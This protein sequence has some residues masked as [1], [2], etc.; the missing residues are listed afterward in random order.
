MK[1]LWTIPKDS[2][3]GAIK[4]VDNVPARN[5]I[6]CSEYIRI[7]KAGKDGAHFSL[8]SD[9]SAR[10][11]VR[12]GAKFPFASDVFLDRR[13]FVP[14]VAGGKESKTTTYEFLIRDGGKLLVKHGNRRAVYE[15]LQ[16]VSGYESLPAIESPHETELDKSW[17]GMVDVASDCA[18]DDPIS[19]NLN[20]VYLYPDKKQL[21]V[22]ASNG[23]VVFLGTVEKQK[24]IREPIAF[25]LKLIDSLKLDNASKLVWTNKL[26]V[27]EF[28]KGKIW[29]AVKIKARKHFPVH[30]LRKMVAD[31]QNN[32]TILAVNS[33][34]LSGIAE[35]LH[36]Y[37]HALSRD[38]MHLNVKLTKDSKRVVVFSGS[39]SSRFEEDLQMLH[40]AKDDA[41]ITWPLE[42]VMPVL[43]FTRDDG[44]A[45]IRLSKDGRSSL[46]TKSTNLIVARQTSKRKKDKTK[47]KLDAKQSDRN[48]D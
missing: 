8:S 31:A 9:L 34:A 15:G 21:E 35:R 39:D 44:I 23:T 46:H 13:L 20:C 10:S 25:P 27:V 11:L 2:L 36:D 30:D 19:P 16:P 32:P 43:I 1:P 47:T 28:P 40:P 42:Q 6:K 14:F 18:T 3:E 41:L 17:I 22:I 48:G 37:V 24:T 29:Q 38:E 5:G 7:S 33:T 4:I 12:N 45:K 26:A